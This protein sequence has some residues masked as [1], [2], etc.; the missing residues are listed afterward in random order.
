MAELATLPAPRLPAPQTGAEKA[1]ILLL[2]LGVEAAAR[3]FR[4]PNEQEVRQV[5]EA[6]ARLRSIPREHAARVQEEAWRWLTNRE[7]LLVDGERFARDLAAGGKPSPAV[8]RDALPG[9]PAGLTPSLGDVAPAALAQLLDHRGMQVVLKEVPREDLM[10]A[11]KTA[12]PA[13]RDK[14]FGNISQRA[15]EILQEDMGSMGPV[16]LKDVEQAQANIISV[17]R[18]LEEEQKITLGGSGEDALV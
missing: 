16:R 6:I 3:V 1:A 9:R 17:V 5:S 15:A 18:R 2:T 11:L 8:E 4:H 14:I 7:G 10:L 13:M 12:S